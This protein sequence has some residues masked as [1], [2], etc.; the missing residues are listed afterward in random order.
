VAEQTHDCADD[1]H[2]AFSGLPQSAGEVL[3][4]FV[5]AQS[6][7]CWKV[8]GRAQPS[9]TE[10]REAG[11]TGFFSG[12]SLAGS[13]AGKGGQLASAFQLFNR[14]DDGQY[15]AGGDLADA[16]DAAKQ[17]DLLAQL[18][19]VP[20]AFDDL[21]FDVFDVLSQD[22]DLAAKV[23]SDGNWSF[24]EMFLGTHPS[25][26]HLLTGANQLLESLQIG[27]AGLPKPRLML[28]AVAGDEFSIMLV[29]FVAAQA[30]AAVVVDEHWVN[31]ADLDLG[32]V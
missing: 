23:F 16:I 9:M 18:R 4:S 3:C 28:L 8:E 21:L 12:L 6:G 32:G 15:S 14:R 2:F 1:H 30:A 31:N 10:L 29:G 13:D 17:L 11:F 22:R 27:A 5:G 20:N 7:E 26:D 25:L 24:L 19:V